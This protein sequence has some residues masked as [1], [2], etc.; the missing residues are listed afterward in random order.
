MRVLDM[1]A[2]L[3]SLNQIH[4][5][6]GKWKLGKEYIRAAFANNFWREI[7]WNKAALEGILEDQDNDIYALIKELKG[8][9]LRGRER[10]NE[11]EGVDIGSLTEALIGNVPPIIK[12]HEMRQLTL[13]ALGTESLFPQLPEGQR[14]QNLNYVF[15]NE[16]KWQIFFEKM[17][18]LHHDQADDLLYEWND[19]RNMLALSRQIH[20][21]VSFL[22]GFVTMEYVREA[23][24]VLGKNSA[25]FVAAAPIGTRPDLVIG[26]DLPNPQGERKFLKFHPDADYVRQVT[27]GYRGYREWLD[28][29]T[30]SQEVTYADINSCIEALSYAVSN[31]IG[32]AEGNRVF[33][34]IEPDNI[35]QSARAIGIE[36]EL[37][38]YIAEE[39]L[40]SSRTGYDDVW[41]FL[42]SASNESVF[43]Q[44]DSVVQNFWGIFMNKWGIRDSVWETF[45]DDFVLQRVKS[46]DDHE[47]PRLVAFISDGGDKKSR[48]DLRN[49]FNR[50][51]DIED[52]DDLRV[53]LNAP[54][55]YLLIALRS[56]FR[57]LQSEYNE[58]ACEHERYTP[59][60]KRLEIGLAEFKFGNGAV[61][62]ESL[63]KAS[64]KEIGRHAAMIFALSG[65]QVGENLDAWYKRVLGFLVVSGLFD[66]RSV[67]LRNS[68]FDGHI[69]MIVGD[70]ICDI[71]KA[72]LSLSRLRRISM[73]ALGNGYIN[74]LSNS[75]ESL[76]F[77][78]EESLRALFKDADKHFVRI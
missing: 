75:L 45:W 40:D 77:I 49:Y 63:R 13:Q 69:R 14:I 8:Y 22:E 2:F 23:R 30:F 24:H 51:F 41:D 35:Y 68:L 29:R 60:D 76:R 28:T 58:F 38:A 64:A 37:E 11:E 57:S 48:K 47:Y 21:M 61:D 6:E 1:R 55:S 65:R 16:E 25:P 54:L 3:E 31:I 4:L 46:E 26:S 67:V 32:T 19:Y 18:G 62:E 39:Y 7:P 71:E 34:G 17:R 15:A 66:V 44:W 5:I 52:F 56:S 9:Y 59:L 72:G 33:A 74:L 10:I 27:G 53:L 78:M 43:N 12:S 42:L 70:E 36:R 20:F 50:G 73:K